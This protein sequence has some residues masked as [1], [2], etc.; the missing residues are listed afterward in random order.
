[1][2]KKVRKRLFEFII[3]THSQKLALFFS[4]FG[5]SL[6]SVHKGSFYTLRTL[7]AKIG[8]KI[9]FYN[10]LIQGIDTFNVMMPNCCDK[11]IK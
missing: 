4:D 2:H 1:M 11:L 10:L 8:S 6:Q 3:L 7:Q 5:K 9:Y